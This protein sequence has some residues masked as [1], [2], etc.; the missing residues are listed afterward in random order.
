MNGAEG[1]LKTLVASGVEVCFANPGTSEMHLVSAIGGTQRMRSVLCLFEGV[2]TGA[3]DGYGRMADR[4]AATLLHV[5]CG[6]SNGMA[7]LHNARKAHSPVVNIVGDHA[8]YHQPLDAPLATDVPAHARIC[9]DWVR[10]SESAADLA[11]SGMSAVAAA[12][13]GAGRIATLIAPANH[14]WEPAGEPSVD[15]EPVSPPGVSTASVEKT[16]ALLSNGKRTGLVLG[17]RGL[18]NEALDTAGRIAEAVGADLLCETFPARLQRG[19]GRIPV[20]RIPYFAE[21]GAAFLD[22]YEQLILVG[23]K[24]PVA[25]FAYP[26][27]PSLLAPEGCTIESLATVDEDIPA[28]LAAVA[29][30]L[31]VPS[32]PSGRQVRSGAEVP[33]GNL[34]PETIGQS[35]CRLMPENTIVVDEAITCSQPIYAATPGAAPHD[36]LAITGGSIGIGLPLALGASVACPDR[37]VVTLQADGSAMYT[38]QALWTMAREQ[39]DVTVVLLNNSSYGILNIELARVG[40]GKPNDKTL[41]MFDLGNPALD[42]VSLSRSLGVAATRAET[43][44]AF[45]HQLDQALAAKGPRLIEA[46]VPVSLDR[47]FG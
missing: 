3:A 9:S 15:P 24:T 38:L 47:I 30:A 35:L 43:A 39:S 7:N 23:G 16:V 44:E 26:G 1:L 13:T 12:R 25:F 21:K 32:M 46:V 41:S 2:A 33:S 4:P 17:G 19:A 40:A 42:W 6:F 14:A 45:D 36:W 8:T 34:S 5:G 28:A 20:R 11:A 27:K 37:K 29:A 31:G 18:R 10:V 22:G